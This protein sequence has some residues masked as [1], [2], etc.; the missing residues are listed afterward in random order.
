MALGMRNRQKP[1]AS[2]KGE[3]RRNPR[4]SVS[5]KSAFVLISFFDS[6]RLAIRR[7][8]RAPKLEGHIRNPSRRH[9]ALL[10]T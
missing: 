3:K 10:K 1:E 8:R 4:Q 7:P 6:L 2:I 5:R 9:G